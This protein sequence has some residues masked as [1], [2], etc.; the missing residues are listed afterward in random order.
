MRDWEILKSAEPSK[1]SS[2]VSPHLLDFGQL[3]AEFA[4]L[5]ESVV[6][7][8]ELNGRLSLLN[9]RAPIRWVLV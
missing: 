3:D 2:N 4:G 9:L 7:W 1:T 5:L 8:S 6:R